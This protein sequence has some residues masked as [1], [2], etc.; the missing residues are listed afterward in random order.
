MVIAMHVPV[1]WHDELAY[2][3]MEGLLSEE[4]NNNTSS[5]SSSSTSAEGTA[6]ASDSALVHR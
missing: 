2:L 3:L 1:Q 5:S 6:D 4:S